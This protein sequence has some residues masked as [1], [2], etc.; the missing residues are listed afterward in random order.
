MLIPTHMRA[1]R[2][3]EYG[4]PLDVLKLEDVPVPAPGPGQLL[5]RAQGIP[6]N[7][8]DIERITGGNMMVRPKFPYAPGMEVMGMVEAAGVG[9]EHWIGK[10]VAA[11]TDNAHGGYAEFCN[12]PQGSAFEVPADVAM[13]DAAALFFPFH[14]AWLGL[15][16][17]AKLSAG[18]TVLIHAAAGGS[19][20]AAIQLAKRVGATVIATA[21][22]AEKLQ[23]CKDLGADHAID[24]N[25]DDFAKVALQIT[26]GKGVDVIFDNVGQAV[27]ERSLKAL[28][29]NGRYLMMGFASDKATAD[30]AVVVPR[31][32]ALG[33]FGIF[34]V[35]LGYMDPKMAM[36]MKMGM[37]ANFA[38]RVLGEQIQASI[39]QMYRDGQIKAVIGQQIG[40]EDIPAAIAAMAERNT[41]GR[42]IATV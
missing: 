34:G 17:R 25:R 22:S 1:W 26:A 24:Y 39:L 5:I 6:L 16:D 29:Y 18:E 23:L 41:V 2:L 35:L 15:Y 4:Q 13:P 12:C 20:S 38:P 3:Y 7:L 28:A 30:K 8:N 40:F 9:A 36:A 33:N 19:G 14:L 31:R 42:V 37:G 27:F 11:V 32:L 21:G 10:R